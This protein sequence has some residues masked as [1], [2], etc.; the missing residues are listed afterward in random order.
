V[1]GTIYLHDNGRWWEDR[2]KMFGVVEHTDGYQV[3]TSEYAPPIKGKTI[4][5]ILVDGVFMAADCNSITHQFDEDFKGF[6]FYDLSFCLPNYLDG[7]NIGVTTDIRILHQSVGI[8]NRLWEANRLQFAEKY[9]AELP[10]F[11]SE[12]EDKDD[13]LVN[14]LTRTHERP[15]FF[16]VCRE[17]ILNQTYK[18][19]NHIVGTDTDCDYYNCIRLTPKEVQYPKPDIGTYPAPWNLHLN[20]LGTCVKEGWVMYLDDDDK[21]VHQNSLKFIVN[22]IEHE[23]QIIF[24]RVNINNGWIVPSD[25]NFGKVVPGNISGIGFMFHSKHLPV[26]WGSWSYGDYRVISKLVKKLEQRWINLVLTQT[27]GMANNG[28]PPLNG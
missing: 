19:I 16:K 6:H 2:S 18:K 23:D 28:R 14:I 3:W 10:I 7:C 1:A 15:A 17:S 13:I 4:P 8:T 22:Q 11:Y 9:K 24:W 5:V 12:Y 26:D 20:E 21:F 25:A 27:Q